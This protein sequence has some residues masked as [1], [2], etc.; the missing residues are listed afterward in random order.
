MSG[1]TTPPPWRLPTWWPDVDNR[2]AKVAIPEAG[3]WMYRFRDPFTGLTSHVFVPDMTA[4]SNSI[5]NAIAA[6][7]N[8]PV[9]IYLNLS[10]VR[11]AKQ[12]VPPA[13]P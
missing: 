13:A 4:W 2:N 12:P 1:F 3:G 11:H 10:A 8:A 9:A 7:K 6:P 5:A